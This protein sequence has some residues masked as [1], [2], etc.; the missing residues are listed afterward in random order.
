MFLKGSIERLLLADKK[1]LLDNGIGGLSL[2]DEWDL[3]KSDNFN[4]DD[5]AGLTREVSTE[6]DDNQD[7]DNS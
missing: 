5:G 3:G 2:V 6:G 1:R 4:S 7:D